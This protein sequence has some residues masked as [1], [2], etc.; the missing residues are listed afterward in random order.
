MGQKSF[1]HFSHQS[2]RRKKHNSSFFYDTMCGHTWQ[3][4]KHRNVMMMYVSVVFLLQTTMQTS[5]P[6]Q[7]EAQIH[8]PIRLFYIPQ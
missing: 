6:P 5:E 4:H 8:P 7:F 3:A 2:H 1:S